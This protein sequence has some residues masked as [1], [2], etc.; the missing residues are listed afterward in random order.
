M[1]YKITQ[2]TKNDYEEAID[3]MNMVFSMNSEPHSFPDLLPV[4]YKPTEEHMKC[5]FVIRIDEKIKA[6]LGLYPSEMI[7]GNESIRLA[8]IGGVCSHPNMREKKLMTELMDFAVEK[9]K[10]DGYDLAGLGGS[11]ERYKYFGF[12]RCG[13]KLV[14]NLGPNNFKHNNIE[15]EGLTFEV[16]EKPDLKVISEL[17]KLYK[18]QPLHINR[19]DDKFLDICRSWKN[20]LH[21]AK[22]E[23]EIVG[24][25][26]PF[27]K[28][29]LS[30]LVAVSDKMR[31]A[32][33]REFCD[34]YFSI[35][36]NLS[37]KEFIRTLGNIAEGRSL[38]ES[39]NWQI[40]NHEKVI[41][42]LLRL[43]NQFYKLDTGEVV[44][45]IEN[46][47][48][49][50]IIVSDA[51]ISCNKVNLVAETCFNREEFMR[52]ALGPFQ[53]SMVT[54][55]PSDLMIFENWFPLPLSISTQDKA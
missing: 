21:I 55:L 17:N 12:E 41:T 46:T 44:F 49:F 52:I 34:G 14:F 19:S 53:P 24:Y 23:G 7:I 39:S 37:E 8:Q 27:G 9:M 35:G 33:M 20:K 38:H 32:I 50:K 51:E 26:V 28:T 3:F 54:E 48:T 25:V 31:I 42:A 36:F 10:N 29:G 30:E 13:I 18:K 40:F 1:N 2:L 5:H 15:K 45:E 16:M 11:R 47:G 4:F 43:K 22:K 6:L